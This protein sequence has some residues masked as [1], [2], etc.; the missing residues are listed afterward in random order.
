VPRLPER[1][2]F[3]ELPASVCLQCG[4]HNQRHPNR[5]AAP[6]RFRFYVLQRRSQ[7]APQL[8]ICFEL[9][10]DFAPFRAPLRRRGELLPEFAADQV[11]ADDAQLCRLRS[12]EALAGTANQQG[13]KLIRLI[14]AP[15]VL[16][17]A[18][19]SGRSH[20]LID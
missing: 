15:G 20:P 1:H 6:L 8:A 7:C 19:E 16:V 2:S 11:R 13:T 14:T 3:F 12:A 17:C 5:A 10:A 18:S 9:L 4:V